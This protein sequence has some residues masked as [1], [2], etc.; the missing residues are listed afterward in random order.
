V[1]IAAVPPCTTGYRKP[2]YS[3]RESYPFGAA[4]F[5][6]WRGSLV[7]DNLAR[8]ARSKW[9]LTTAIANTVSLVAYYYALSTG[10]IYAVGRMFFGRI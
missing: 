7:I 5:L 3:Q 1:S 4:P 8:S 6:R 2:T 9:Y 10:R